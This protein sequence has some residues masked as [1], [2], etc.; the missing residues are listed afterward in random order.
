MVHILRNILI[1]IVTVVGM[2]F[3]RLIAFAVVTE[4]I[5]S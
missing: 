3:G 2:S 1:P 4:S 5:F